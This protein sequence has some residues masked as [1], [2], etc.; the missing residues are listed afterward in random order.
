ML[1]LPRRM[2]ILNDQFTE[3]YAP[4]SPFHFQHHQI[5]VERLCMCSWGEMRSPVL[6]HYPLSVKSWQAHQWSDLRIRR[7]F[8]TTQPKEAC[9]TTS[10]GSMKRLD[11]CREHHFWW[12]D[13]KGLEPARSYVEKSGCSSTYLHAWWKQSCEGTPLTTPS[14]SDKQ[15]AWGIIDATMCGKPF[16]GHR[17]IRWA[18]IYTLTGRRIC[19]D[20]CKDPISPPSFSWTH[21]SMKL[22]LDFWSLKSVCAPKSF[23]GHRKPLANSNNKPEILYI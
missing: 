16:S 22:K 17:V 5:V 15:I 13:C 14:F 23:L 19:H 4:K 1:M 20:Y 21:D 12:R 9:S 8:G 10:K 18:S 7:S 6:H 2:L 11:A 3:D